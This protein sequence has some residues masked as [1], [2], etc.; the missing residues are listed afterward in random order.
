VRR[1]RHADQTNDT[2]STP[3]DEDE[4]KGNSVTMSVI[5]TCRSSGT[6][7]VQVTDPDAEEKTIERAYEVGEVLGLV[8]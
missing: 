6:V 2:R 5:S 3:R 4:Q 1:C 8:V 7:V